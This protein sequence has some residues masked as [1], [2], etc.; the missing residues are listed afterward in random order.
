MMQA[1]NQ[2][3]L[4]WGFIQYQPEA[5]PKPKRKGVK[6]VI[7]HLREHGPSTTR[8]IKEATGVTPTYSLSSAKRRPDIFNIERTSDATGAV[9]IISLVEPDK[10]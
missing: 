6:C 9:C 4:G 8:E 1:L 3:P 2:L 10:Q 7:D 5:K